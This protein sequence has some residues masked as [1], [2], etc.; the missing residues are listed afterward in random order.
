M[1][2][3]N[4]LYNLAAL[5]LGIFVVAVL[6]VSFE[7]WLRFH[8]RMEKN[9]LFSVNPDYLNHFAIFSRSLLP[10]KRD[11][12]PRVFCVGGSTTNGCNMPIPF[13]YPN[14]IQSIY[15]DKHKPGTVYNF[16]VSGVGSVTTNFFVKHII[17]RY[18][19]QCVVIHDGY[20]DLPIVISKLGDDRYSYITP[21]YLNTFNPYIPN[22]VLRYCSSF[23]RFNFRATR[24]FV[25]TRILPVRNDVFLGYDYKKYPLHEG[26][27]EQIL[28][29]NNKR[30]KIML[31]KEID[32]IDY[33]LQ[34]G[35][36][37]IVI[38]EP[39]I[40]PL[41]FS[42][43][44]T[45]SM[46]D[47]QVGFILSECHQAQQALF[48]FALSQKYGDN[49]NVIILDMREIFK[50]RYKD[51]FYDECHLNGAGNAVKAEI[52]YNYLQVFFP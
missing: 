3:K 49:K 21:D 36:K 40:R 7:V 41:H 11:S 8:Y 19:P 6:I 34:N 9:F 48:A 38:L 33:C 31:K 32:T 15:E 52:V 2:T 23:I 10:D 5:V 43:P 45:S 16:G 30:L 35:I 25:L 14:L 50:D 28:A 22:P 20:N 29:E 18:D 13:S 24:R 47:P 12:A 51:L 46:R 44:F 37:V 4:I 39:H 26:T 17:P 27:K 1:K 42:P